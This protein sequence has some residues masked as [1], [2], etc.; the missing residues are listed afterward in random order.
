MTKGAATDK[1][2]AVVGSGVIG[3][4]WAALFLAH[5]LSVVATDPA[6]DAER[7]LLATIE[8]V[9]PTVHALGALAHPPFERLSFT[10]S[11]GEA[12][13]QAVFVQENGP[14]RIDLKHIV[15]AQIDEAAGADVVIASSSSG[16]LPSVIQSGCARHPERVVIG[17]PFN[18]PHLIPLVEVVGGNATAPWAIDTAMA[19]YRSVHR[20]PVHLRRELPGHLANRLQAALWREA[21]ALID[22]GAA[23]VTDIDT[24]IT[25]GPGLRWAAIG[26]FASFH[27]S[28]GEGGIGHN[29]E[30]LGPPMVDW[31]NTLTQPEL[32]DELVA[33]VVEQMG[34]E[35]DGRTSADLE[36]DRDSLIVR[37]LT[38]RAA[39]DDFH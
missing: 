9:W 18:P 29:L 11:V 22:S 24:V 17:H 8:Q 7:L 19:F 16:L 12:V 1:P 5:G 20:E 39:T 37:I 28:G 25:N 6:P 23:T 10:A 3:R 33:T 38:E 27:L 34:D 4:S 2:I 14:E 35:L 31:W 15:M 36:R 13:S 32:T 21:F 30:H 26:P